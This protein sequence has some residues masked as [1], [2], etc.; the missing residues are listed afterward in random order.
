[1]SD[2][3]Q[4]LCFHIVE[5]HCP[6]ATAEHLSH[7]FSSRQYL[8]HCRLLLG[9]NTQSE[10]LLFPADQANAILNRGFAIA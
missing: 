1:M 3:P 8:G 10:R 5:M 9:I 6:A 2:R 7:A 4:S